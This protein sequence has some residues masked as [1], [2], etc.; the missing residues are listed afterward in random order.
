MRDCRKRRFALLKLAL[1]RKIERYFKE[2]MNIRG[3][4][5]SLDVKDD[6]GV[7]EIRV[8]TH[9]RHEAGETEDGEPEQRPNSR[10]RGS[11]TNHST[12]RKTE[13]RVLQDLRGDDD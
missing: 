11:D 10:G 5:A 2:Y 3:Y 6:K 8:E 12:S 13:K 9:Q 7:I 1:P 4:R